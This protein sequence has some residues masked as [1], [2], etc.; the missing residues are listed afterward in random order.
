VS[1]T[2]TP[3]TIPHRAAEILRALPSKSRGLSAAQL[4]EALGQPGMNVAGFLA[5]PRQHGFF[6]AEKIEGLLFWSMGD[7]V[8]LKPA[9]ADDEPPVQRIVPANTKRGRMLPIV[10]ASP[11][12]PPPNAAVITEPVGL[13]IDAVHRAVAAMSIQALKPT[14]EARQGLRLALW[15][16]GAL[17]IEPGTERMEFGFDE[18]RQ[19]VAYLE[20]IGEAA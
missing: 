12:P 17:N 16:D 14:A 19:I 3:G 4:A 5:V 13:N 15:S 1:Y 18:V 20:R 9:E 11:P 6:K 2:P 10:N 7:G 8:S